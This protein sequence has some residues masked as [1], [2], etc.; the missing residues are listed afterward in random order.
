MLYALICISQSFFFSHRRMQLDDLHAMLDNV[1]SERDAALNDLRLAGGGAG[2]VGTIGDD[3]R[4]VEEEA[5]SLRREC[6][7][8]R[9]KVCV[10]NI[11]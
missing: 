2:N 7:E 3:A 5:E 4:A 9:E 6:E 11:L 1:A 10:F 8:L